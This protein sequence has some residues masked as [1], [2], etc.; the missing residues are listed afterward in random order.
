MTRQ[1]LDDCYFTHLVEPREV[2]RERGVTS[3]VGGSD[4]LITCTARGRLGGREEVRGENSEVT[5]TV[6]PRR[7]SAWRVGT[8][9]RWAE[10]ML[11]GRR[12]RI[13]GT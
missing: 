3:E 8:A 13:S 9:T 6:R 1:G 7:H 4:H 11:A 5:E 10:R 12:G 2:R